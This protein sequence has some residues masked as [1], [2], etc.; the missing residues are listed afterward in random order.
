LK[1]YDEEYQ[2]LWNFRN[3]EQQLLDRL[4]DEYPTGGLDGPL[5]TAQYNLNTEY[6]LRL[7]SIKEK[8]GRTDDREDGAREQNEARRN[9]MI[10]GTGMLEG[11]GY[12]EI[13]D[14]LIE[15]H[16]RLHKQQ[17]ERSVCDV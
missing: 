12:Y 16:L 5:T 11:Y 2:E 1:T 7:L 6:N 9:W 17:R 3:T 8:H 15:Q 10:S 14:Y 13:R 4:H